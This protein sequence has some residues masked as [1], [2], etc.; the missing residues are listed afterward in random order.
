M[1]SML[2]KE[3][4]SVVSGIKSVLYYKIS[5]RM[6]VQSEVAHLLGLEPYS[7]QS[8]QRM[9]A[10]SHC[11]AVQEYSQPEE[12]L[13]SDMIQDVFPVESNKK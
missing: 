4:M 13:E 6:E 2:P 1:K 7:N 11:L 8:P 3:T 9:E 12:T 5:L 10:P